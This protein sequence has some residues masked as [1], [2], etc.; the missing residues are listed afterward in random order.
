[1]KS[2]QKTANNR[3][4]PRDWYSK[5]W[6]THVFGRVR[7]GVCGLT[8]NTQLDLS[9]GVAHRAGGGA[10]IEACILGRG[11]WEVEVSIRIGLQEGAVS[12]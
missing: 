12:G 2:E 5:R 6:K 10:D 1:M 8:V 7:S 11:Q 9:A 4:W 3:Q